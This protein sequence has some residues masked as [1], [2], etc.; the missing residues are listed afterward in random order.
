MVPFHEYS[1]VVGSHLLQLLSEWSLSQMSFFP[2]TC[3]PFPL[4]SLSHLLLCG[5]DLFV[6]GDLFMG[7]RNTLL[8]QAAS[9]VSAH[10]GEHDRTPSLWC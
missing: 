10:H 2:Y 9:S 1:L 4:V 6:F 3:L 5:V 8:F 7:R